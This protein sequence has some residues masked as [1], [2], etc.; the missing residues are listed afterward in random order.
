[1]KNI[2]KFAL[3]LEEIR[4]ETYAEPPEDP[5]GELSDIS[6]GM[7]R[8]CYEHNRQVLIEVGN[9]KKRIFLEPDIALIWE[10]LPSKI[11]TLSEGKPIEIDFSESCHLIL[12]FVPRG[13][14][15]NCT[16]KEFGRSLKEKQFELDRRQVLETLTEFI[17]KIID[18]ATEK[19]YITGL[20]MSKFVV[21][22]LAL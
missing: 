11:S 10:R 18:G 1:M 15:I 17:R 7:R 8:F 12:K 20:E 4:V 14:I 9:E 16:F 6:M 13:D 5:L 2:S 22:A 19:G 21:S 3:K